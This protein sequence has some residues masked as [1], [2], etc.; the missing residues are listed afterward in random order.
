[1]DPSSWILIFIVFLL[2]IGGGFFASAETAFAS[3]N[4]IRIK[5]MAEDGNKRAKKAEYILNNFSKTLSTLLIGNNIMHIATA[6]ITTYIV[7]STWGEGYTAYATIVTTVVVFLFAEMLPKQYAKDKPESTSLFYA[8]AVFWLMKIFTP[9]SYVFDAIASLITKLFKAKPEPIVTEE[10]F[11]ELIEILA[12]NGEEENLL[13]SALKFDNK[14]AREIMTPMKDVVYI[15]LKTEHDEIIETIREN[16]FSRLPIY[17]ENSSTITGLF[18]VRKAIKEHL[19]DRRKKLNPEELASAPMYVSTSTLIDDLF[20]EMTQSKTHMCVVI[21]DSDN[22][23]SVGI[24]TMEDILE[25]LVGEIW[26]EDD[27]IPKEVSS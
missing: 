18:D 25:E 7:A 26:D 2:L 4:P 21:D 15:T 27:E 5:H 13:H 23:K 20:D 14:T 9:I 22:Y 17:D 10:E 12:D 3:L 19:E 16:K 11:E 6:T 24:I 1:M 8:T